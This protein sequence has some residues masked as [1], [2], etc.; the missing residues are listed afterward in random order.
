M[1]KKAQLHLKNNDGLNCLDY[2]IKGLDGDPQAL[3]FKIWLKDAYPPR[4]FGDFRSQSQMSTSGAVVDGPKLS[5]EEVLS[6]ANLGGP[7]GR[8][9][10]WVSL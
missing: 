8:A 9:A 6:E 4:E 3:K 5:A 1:A 10:G 2:C 7:S